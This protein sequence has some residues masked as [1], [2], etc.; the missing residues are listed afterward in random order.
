M[1]VVLVVRVHVLMFEDLVFVHVL[2]AIGESEGNTNSHNCGA[3]D[4]HGRKV[5]VQ[6]GGTRAVR[7]QIARSANTAL[8]AART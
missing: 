1:L 2:V 4:V 8:Y 5:L 7:P 6:D 3:D